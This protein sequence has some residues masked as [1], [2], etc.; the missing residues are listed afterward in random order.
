MNV[1]FFILELFRRRTQC[2][3]NRLVLDR[4]SAIILLVSF[5]LSFYRSIVVCS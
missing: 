5:V 4:I 3:F 2:L 1:S